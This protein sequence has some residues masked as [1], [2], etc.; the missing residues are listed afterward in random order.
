MD[1]SPVEH[2][3][4]DSDSGESWTIL[5]ASPAYA[6]E[7]PEL[8][9]N[10]PV[11]EGVPR[12]RDTIEISCEKD[13]DTD[14]ISIISDS[15]PESSLPCELNCQKCLLE[16]NHPTDQQN[17]QYFSINPLP[18]D[19]AH[20]ESIKDEE[21]F[22]GDNARIHKTYVHRRNKRLSTVLNIIVLGS[23]I[24]AAGVAIGHMWGAKNDC[25]MQSTPSVNKIL[26]NLYKLQ[27]ENAYLRNKLKELTL[28]NNLQ[29]QQKKSGSEKWLKQHKCKKVF[30]ESLGNR[31]VE[32]YTKCVDID[33]SAKVQP[34]I[35]EPDYEKDFLSDI[36]Q[37]KL[38]Y[39][40]NKSW[41]DEEISKRNNKKKQT[42]DKLKHDIIENLETKTFKDKNLERQLETITEAP[43]LEKITLE[44]LKSNSLN[45]SGSSNFKTEKKISYADSL[46][47]ETKG[48]VID[49]RDINIHDEN[50][51]KEYPYKHKAKKIRDSVSEY[52]VSDDE[53]KKDDRYIAPKH[54]QERKKHDRQKSHKK[55]K[56]KNKYEQW[57]M[58][59]GYIK[60]YDVSSISSFQDIE[61]ENILNNEE[62]HKI[63]D[64]KDNVGKLPES[65][66]NIQYASSVKSMVKEGKKV[67]KGKNNKEKDTTWFDNRALLRMEAR[68]KLHFDLFGETSPNTAGWYFRRMQ[69]REQCRSKGDNSTHK[70]FMKRNMN[71]KTKH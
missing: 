62:K 50:M 27:E 68:K 6:D 2:S 67:I 3:G 40:H 35:V 52:S 47:M 51:L 8:P 66:E 15:D 28:I 39:E 20:H 61:I 34:H 10:A 29:M 30:E 16:E 38:V 31:N 65:D 11:P 44:S 25:T 43:N 17:A 45:V 13:E 64:D 1:G 70:K 56:R 60:D 4:S 63:N 55:Q 33:N 57:E 14:G 32:K 24:T 12:N 21:D 54:K 18:S 53:L 36:E 59:G 71:F 37:L 49:K 42:A 5:E 22:L 19:N 58:K 69:R 48:K 41:L 46:Q 9:E 23:V 7:L 26:S